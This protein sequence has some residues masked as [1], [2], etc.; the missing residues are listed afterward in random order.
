M[1]AVK[2]SHHDVDIDTEGKDSWRLRNAGANPTA[3]VAGSFIAVMETAE[4]SPSLSSLA[5]MLEGK[6]DI[7]LAEGFKTEEDV[8]MLVFSDGEEAPAA[9]V[10]GLVAG[11]IVPGPAPGGNARAPVFQR[12]DAEGVA[13]HIERLFREWLKRAQTAPDSRKG[14]T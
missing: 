2:R 8:P 6:A 7:V 1:G 14:S 9:H 3:L 11:Y 4:E 5:G 10:A 12:D 13:G